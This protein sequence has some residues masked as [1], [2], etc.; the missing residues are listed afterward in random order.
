M[1]KLLTHSK[2]II[3]PDRNFICSPV[4]INNTVLRALY[5][6]ADQFLNKHDLLSAQITGSHPPDIINITAI[7]LKSPNSTISSFLLA[8]PD[9]SLYVNFD[10]DNYTPVTSQI[11]DIEILGSEKLQAKSSIFQSSDF[12]N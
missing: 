12:E 2:L 3:V 1:Q 5:T 11:F 8:L 9:Y 4:T 7:L 6:N 10:P